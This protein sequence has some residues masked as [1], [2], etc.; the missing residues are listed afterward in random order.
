MTK[1][2]LLIL[3][4]TVLNVYGYEYIFNDRCINELYFIANT[5]FSRTDIL[6][7]KDSMGIILRFPIKNPA[8]ECRELSTETV[9]NLKKIEQFL[10]KIENSVIIEVHTTDEDSV[11]RNKLNN[12]EIA[13]VIAGKAEAEIRELSGGL[14]YDRIS[15]VGYG[16]FSPVKNP[17]YNG[18]KYLNR[19][20]IIVQ[21][22]ISG[23]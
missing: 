16:E 23:E 2:I 10:A 4:F 7:E 12:W 14:G 17:P 18:G 20:D 6:V 21:C 5:E 22:N 15:S 11:E 19:I 8:E 3:L 9:N 1:Y 13:A